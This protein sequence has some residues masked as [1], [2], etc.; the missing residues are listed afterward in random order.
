[1]TFF[2]QIYTLDSNLRSDGSLFHMS[3]NLLFHDYFINKILLFIGEN[4]HPF[5]GFKPIFNILQVSQ[6]HNRQSRNTEYI[7]ISCLILSHWHLSSWLDTLVY[8]FILVTYLAA[9]FVPL[10]SMFPL[11]HYPTKVTHIII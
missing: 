3:I 7:A 2:L 1:M 9:W 5:M 6:F 10:L 4:N 11:P 8:M